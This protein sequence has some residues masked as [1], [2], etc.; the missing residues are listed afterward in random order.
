MR[1]FI[2]ESHFVTAECQFPGIRR[3]YE[4]LAAKPATFLELVWQYVHDVECGQRAPVTDDLA[5]RPAT[6]G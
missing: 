4:A 6:R 5:T 3:F 2:N 1:G